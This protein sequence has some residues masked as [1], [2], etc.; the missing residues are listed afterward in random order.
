MNIAFRAVSKRSTTTW[1]VTLILSGGIA[2]S[3][4]G[5]G[6]PVFHLDFSQFAD[7][8]G[9]NLPVE[10]GDAVSLVP[11]GGPM[12]GNGTKL[13]SA[14]WEGV[15]DDTNQILILDHAILDAVTVGPGS[16]VTWINPEEGNDW[17]NIAKT[18]CEDN[19]EP[20]DEF[21]QFRG[22]EF[23]ASGPHAGVFGAVQGWDT[24]V[25]SPNAPPP[26]G[27]GDGE[28]DTP[29]GEWTHAALVWNADG[30]HTIF[31]NGEPGVTVEG[32][33]AE[34]F[35]LNTTGNW[36]IGGDGL[37]AAGPNSPDAFRYLRGQLADFAIYNGELTEQEIA[38]IIQSGVRTTTPGDFNRDGALDLTDVNA[39]SGS[40]ASGGADL[41]F[42]VNRDSSVNLTDLQVWVKD[43][44][45]TWFGDAN[46][47]GEFNSADFVNVFQAGKYEIDEQATWEEGDWTA[48]LR[49]NSGDFVAAFQDG[50]YEKGPRPAAASLPEPGSGLLLVMGAAAAF[51]RRSRSGSSRKQA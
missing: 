47:N 38:Q 46:L 11:D 48:D 19:L 26:Y 40:I 12:L 49:F 35:G 21:S 32:V 41:T 22:I 16:I 33:G 3:A 25:F 18:P 17:N 27:N 13:D 5:A 15:E 31:V 43:L 23:Q 4:N 1:I 34:E 42:D 44:K 24:N 30:D 50:G 51:G 14:L 36:T 45:K 7:M 6:T 39:L 2:L 29:S 37:G 10:V 9:N 8:S 20:C 28:T